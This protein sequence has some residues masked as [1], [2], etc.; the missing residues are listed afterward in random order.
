MSE[1][2]ESIRGP[3]MLCSICGRIDGAL[4]G[5]TLWSL[6]DDQERPTFTYL[7]CSICNAELDEIEAAIGMSELAIME[8]R[9]VMT[10][11]EQIASETVSVSAIVIEKVRAQQASTNRRRFKVIDG[12]LKPEK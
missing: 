7:P 12:G 11:A 6:V 3:Q 8:L 2:N 5:V 1:Q 4:G 10:D 9:A